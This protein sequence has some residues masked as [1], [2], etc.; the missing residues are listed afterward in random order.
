M[1]MMSNIFSEKDIEISALY[2]QCIQ[3]SNRMNW[4][5][6]ENKIS[7]EARIFDVSQLFLL[8]KLQDIKE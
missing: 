3:T 6:D 1:N 2:A 4:H 8:N 7:K 5:L